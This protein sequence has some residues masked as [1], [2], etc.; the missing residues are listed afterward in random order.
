[1]APTVSV[2]TRVSD[3]LGYQDVCGL[4]MTLGACSSG[5]SRGGGSVVRTSAASPVMY[6]ASRRP[7]PPTTPH[8]ADDLLAERAQSLEPRRP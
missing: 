7:R 6:E 4:R 2:L 8:D 3:R 1:M 5:A